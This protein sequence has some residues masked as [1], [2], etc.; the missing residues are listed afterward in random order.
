[1]IYSPGIACKNQN[2][3]KK[4]VRSFNKLKCPLTRASECF[5]F[6]RCTI[7]SG[8]TSFSFW[9]GLLI[10]CPPSPPHTL[11]KDSAVCAFHDNMSCGRRTPREDAMWWW[12]FKLLTTCT[13]AITELLTHK[14][15]FVKSPCLHPVFW[16]SF[17]SPPP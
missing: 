1:M 15:V 17:L 9:I 7:V 2:E 11:K 10:T 14:E 16:A 3:K 8:T 6:K 12:N 5:V 4:E 13:Y